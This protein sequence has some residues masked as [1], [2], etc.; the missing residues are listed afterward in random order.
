[1]Q[2]QTVEVELGAIDD[3]RVGPEPFKYRLSPTDLLQAFSVIGLVLLIYMLL[4]YFEISRR[5]H[6][7]SGWLDATLLVTI[8]MVII[9]V[10]T[11]TVFLRDSVFWMSLVISS[12]MQLLVLHAWSQ[13]FQGFRHGAGKLAS[14]F[15]FVLFYAIY[16]LVRFLQKHFNGE[17]L[18]D[19]A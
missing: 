16:R 7:N 8:P 14:L 13:R 2:P 19:G 9:V 6:M 3:G 17:Q 4:P 11:R 12:A 15:G 1:M 10:A 5:Y 18:P